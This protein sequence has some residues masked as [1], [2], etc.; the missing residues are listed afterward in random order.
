[1]LR[2]QDYLFYDL[3]KRFL[4]IEFRIAP[5]CAGLVLT[6]DEVPRT[7]HHRCPLFLL[8]QR[9]NHVLSFSFQ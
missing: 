6:L 2:G 9:A 8:L 1:M 4:F 5:D 7:K 3:H